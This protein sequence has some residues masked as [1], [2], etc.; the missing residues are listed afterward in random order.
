MHKES[1][2]WCQ[3][4]VD[5]DALKDNSCARWRELTHSS[6]GGLP[7]YVLI[8]LNTDYNN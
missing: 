2:M 1:S 5:A 8:M 7:I 6:L 3:C 4:L